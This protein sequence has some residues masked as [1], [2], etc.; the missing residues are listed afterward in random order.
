MANNYLTGRGMRFHAPDGKSVRVKSP[1][2]L[3]ANYELTLPP[4]GGDAQQVLGTDG[5]GVT[6]WVTVITETS[7]ATLSNKTYTDPVLNGTISGTAFLDEDDFASDSATKVASQQ[8]IKAY[9][10]AQLALSG[11]TP[12]GTVIASFATSTPTGYLYCNG[13]AVSRTTYADLF[14]AI[15]ESCGQGDNSTTFNLPDLRGRFLRGQDDGASRDPNDTTRTAM[16]TGGNTGD[17]VGS[18]QTDAFQGHE[19]TQLGTSAATS[20][21]GGVT[22]VAASNQATQAIVT[23]GSSG[24]PRTS[25][26]TRPIN[27]SVRYYI[28]F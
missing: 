3:T 25:T 24:T 15:G 12:A 6:D 4:D 8:S 23:D 9:I 13:A 18:V 28:K 26:E 20:A 21:S 2:T 17:N 5:N 27:A 1:A 16:A 22:R 19:H 14:T 11:A 7:S 10:A